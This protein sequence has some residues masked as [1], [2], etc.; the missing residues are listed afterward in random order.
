MLLALCVACTAAAGGCHRESHA[1][2]QATLQIAA[3]SDLSIAF[4]EVGQA[5]E[6]QTGH[7]VTFSFGSTGTLAK[8]LAE[9]APF[10]LF[11]AANESFLK[12]PIEAGACDPTTEALY[13][14]GHIVV[15]TKDVPA[16]KSLTELT[17]PRFDHIAIANPQTAPYG[18]A[19]VE[20]LKSAG[21]YDQVKPKLVYG[22]N[23]QQTLQLAQSGNAAA[24]IVALS[25]AKVTPGNTLAIDE[26][27][28]QPID[29]ALIVCNHGQAKEAA[30]EFA[31]FLKKGE[32]H[33]IMKRY[34]FFLPGE[35]LALNE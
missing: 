19:A 25:L 18:K 2:G 3:A 27:M 15:W 33:A 13:A 4:K 5:F 12:I 21:V 11:A 1:G 35:K 26:S 6:K 34:G 8:Q 16:P 31:A 28:H 29:Q 24:A 9:G 23:V 20:A 17:D 14:R 22:S 30:K 32:T 10:D 7:K